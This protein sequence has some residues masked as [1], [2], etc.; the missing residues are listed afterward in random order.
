MSLCPE[1]QYRES[2][3][4]EEFWA[5]I[6]QTD[7]EEYIDFDDI[8]HSPELPNPCKVCGELTA[9]GY[10]SEGRPMIHSENVED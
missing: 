10:D 3:S 7:Y 9:C 5:H 4:D 2:L 8:D 1:F 6:F